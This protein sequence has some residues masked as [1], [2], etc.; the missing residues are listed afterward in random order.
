M[1]SKPNRVYKHDGWH[2]WGHW[3]G[4]GNQL[5]KNFLPFEEA[6]MAGRSLQL[7]NHK[8]WRAWCKS[9]ARPANV[10]SAPDQVYKH[11]GWH[12]WEHWLWNGN[13]DTAA[14][15]PAARNKRKQAATGS[16]AV[17]S[18]KSTGKQQRR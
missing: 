16:A 5:A 4:T 9:G 2:G 8:E 13:P 6:L 17:A 1:P 14:A 7:A 15:P 12:G 10:P 11:D 18:A 3:L